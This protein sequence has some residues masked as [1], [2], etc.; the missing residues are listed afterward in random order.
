METDAAICGM[1][2]ICG[3][4]GFHW[5]FFKFNPR[6]LPWSW[7]GLKFCKCNLLNIAASLETVITPASSPS[8]YK[9]LFVI[10]AINI[11]PDLFFRGNWPDHDCP[12]FNPSMISFRGVWYSSATR[13]SAAWQPRTSWVFHPYRFSAERFLG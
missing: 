4:G 11:W 12:E 3:R 2:A 6:A 5:I 1:D 10:I 13:R 8:S 9:G 7:D